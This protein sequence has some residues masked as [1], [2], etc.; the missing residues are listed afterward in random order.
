MKHARIMPLI[1]AAL[2]VASI[3]TV[4]PVAAAAAY[5]DLSI[6]K[7]TPSLNAYIESE[8]AGAA[9]LRIN[10]ELSFI[11]TWVSNPG[12]D[13][14]EADYRFL[15]DDDFL[16][17]LEIRKDTE[18]DFAANKPGEVMWIGDSTI[19][20]LSP[21]DNPNLA[22]DD[23]YQFGAGSAADPGAPIINKRS[24]NAVSAPS[25][26]SVIWSSVDESTSTTIV[27]FDWD[28][29]TG[30]RAAVKEGGR[31][32]LAI[33][34]CQSTGSVPP[35]QSYQYETGDLS[36]GQSILC[37]LADAGGNVPDAPAGADEPD[38]PDDPA[39]FTKQSPAPPASPS[40]AASPSSPSSDPSA[41]SAPGG[42]EGGGSPWIWVI[43]IAA[44]VVAGVALYFALNKKN[45]RKN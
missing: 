33:V 40:S 13:E 28:D 21:D 45:R 11:P 43:V 25:A 44:V 16:Y 37:Y 36:G 4:S 14:L 23:D 1:M 18:L 41:S 26:K 32:R 7:G 8:W 42:G 20:F 39:D 30:L 17:L 10:A 15:W 19:F 31:I 27:A 35:S 12:G 29:F 3:L 38:E 2:A 6:P 9:A 24:N 22:S 5:E 34:L